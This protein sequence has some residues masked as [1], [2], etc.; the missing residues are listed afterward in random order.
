MQ[1]A[2]FKKDQVLKLTDLPNFNNKVV[3]IKKMKYVDK[4]GWLYQPCE[5]ANYHFENCFVEFNK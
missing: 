4:L 1:N 3:K 2:K 5:S